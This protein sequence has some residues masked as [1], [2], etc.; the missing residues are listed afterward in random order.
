[1]QQQ[2][3]NSAAVLQRWFNSK[4]CAHNI[5]MFRTA[6]HR[7]ARYIAIPVLAPHCVTSPCTRNAS[8]YYLVHRNAPQCTAMCC[9]VLHRAASRCLVLHCAAL[10]CIASHRF[11]LLCIILHN[12]AINRFAL[13]RNALHCAASHCIASQFIAPHLIALHCIT[14]HC[15][16]LHRTALHRTT[17]LHTVLHRPA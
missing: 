13:H 14:L 4:R 6:L 17:P 9:N 15:I 2:R 3:S 8:G 16:A 1:M 5:A 7:T 10:C 11:T 12:I